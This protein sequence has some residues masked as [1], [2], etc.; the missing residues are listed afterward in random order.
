MPKLREGNSDSTYR[1]ASS[2]FIP[3]LI[4]Q[5]SDLVVAGDVNV[6]LCN[7]GDGNGVSGGDST[8]AGLTGTALTLFHLSVKF[9]SCSPAP[10]DAVLGGRVKVGG[11][12][13]VIGGRGGDALSPENPLLPVQAGK[14]SGFSFSLD[15]KSSLDVSGNLHLHLHRQPKRGIRIIDR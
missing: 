2:E 3:H 9:H 10:I 15:A 6:R 14:G 12:M 5:Y 4:I 13:T 1:G 7:A 8:N 11:S